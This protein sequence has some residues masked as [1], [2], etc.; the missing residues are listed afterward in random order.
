M[1]R[2]E[3]KKILPHRDPMLLVDHVE[4][5]DGICT[6]EYT[7]R[8]DEFFLKGH[9][10]DNP[11]VPGVMLCEMM[12]QASC[13]LIEADGDFLPYFTKMDNVKFRKPV[14]PKDKITFE[15]H[16]TSVRKPFCFITCK[17]YVNDVLCVSGDFSFA[18]MKKE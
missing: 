16:V 18:I 4:I 17:G 15:S 3:I 9:F 13:L 5:K 1:D 14:K 8:G 6:G 10:P 11:V 7:V 2:E 12:G